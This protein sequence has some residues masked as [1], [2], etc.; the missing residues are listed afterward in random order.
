MTKF[1][2]GDLVKITNLKNTCNIGRII[3]H[4]DITYSWI[5]TIIGHIYQVENKFLEL[6]IRNKEENNG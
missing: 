6:I 1:K 3:C 4:P 5:R 2:K